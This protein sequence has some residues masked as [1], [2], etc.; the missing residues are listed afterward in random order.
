MSRDRIRRR[1]AATGLVGLFLLGIV[2]LPVGGVIII[3]LLAPILIAGLIVG[4][5]VMAIASLFTGRRR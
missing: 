3:G 4:L 2:L 1:D 5:I